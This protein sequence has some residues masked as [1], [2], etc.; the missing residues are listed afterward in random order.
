[1][2]TTW[3][4]PPI[5]PIGVFPKGSDATFVEKLAT[6]HKSNKLFK[7]ITAG[8]QRGCFSISHYAGEVTYNS[9][10]FLIKVSNK[11]T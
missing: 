1:M 9:A 7:L 5:V 11:Q 8:K 4:T 10:G 3:C 6:A 2:L